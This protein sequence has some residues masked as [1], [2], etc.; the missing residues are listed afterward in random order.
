MAKDEAL[1][2]PLIYTDLRPLGCGM[3]SSPGTSP[4]SEGK[5]GHKHRLSKPFLFVFLW[6]T[7]RRGGCSP[8]AHFPEPWSTRE[9]SS[10]PGRE[11]VEH[12]T[13]RPRA[14]QPGTEEGAL[15]DTH[16]L[17]PTSCCTPSP[18]SV[19]GG[20][21][22]SLSGHE[23]ELLMQLDGPL[24][25]HTTQAE[26]PSVPCMSN[27]IKHITECHLQSFPPSPAIQCVSGKFQNSVC[28]GHAG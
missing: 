6:R 18:T 21:R 23:R 22:R 8:L 19:P 16:T 28:P 2:W 15:L 17:P 9:P 14:S 7:P 27:L 1:L 11:E 3:T 10:H 24:S 13:P 20:H 25:R 5:C 4:F 12:A 26:T